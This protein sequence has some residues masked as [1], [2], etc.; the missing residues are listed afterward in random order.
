MTQNDILPL[1]SAI[2]LM[3]TNKTLRCEIRGYHSGVD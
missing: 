1:I 2:Y 3:A